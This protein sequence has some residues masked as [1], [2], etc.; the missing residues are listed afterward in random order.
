MVYIPK[1]RQW[2]WNALAKDFINRFACNVEIIP[3]RYS[4]EKMKQKFNE[5]YREFSYRWHKEAARVQP[6][7]SEKERV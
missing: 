3:N 5:S 6:P 2:P 4:L 7:M 1:I